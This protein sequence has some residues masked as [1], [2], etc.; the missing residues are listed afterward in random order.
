[1]KGEGSSSA[2]NAPGSSRL[3]E[4]EGSDAQSL[5]RERSSLTGQV[6]QYVPDSQAQNRERIRGVNPEP[7]QPAPKRETTQYS[8]H[9]RISQTKSMIAPP[10]VSTSQPQS[11]FFNLS[12]GPTS[13]TPQ[14]R[15]GTNAS[16]KPTTNA[17]A[18][19][20][21]HMIVVETA[22]VSDQVPVEVQAAAKP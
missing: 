14:T 3:S 19:N 9:R 5:S 7:P 17:T 4:E 20:Q 10:M 1:V 2:S 12:S 22:Q 16:E 11:F 15:P 18:Q 6:C 8:T 13:I 21:H